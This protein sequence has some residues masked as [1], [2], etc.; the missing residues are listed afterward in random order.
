MGA[1][2]SS[3]AVSMR[4]APTP[5]VLG[6][7]DS[8]QGGEHQGITTALKAK[9]SP[10]IVISRWDPQ[11]LTV[12]TGFNRRF[13]STANW[14]AVCNNA[15]DVKRCVDACGFFGIR[16]TI[17]S[18][19]HCYENF[20]VENS[21]GMIIDCAMMNGVS[22]DASGE[23]V[24][25]EPGIYNWQASLAMFKLFNKTLPSGSCYSVCA[26]GHICGGGY[27]LL[28]RLYGVTSDYLAGVE[29]VT[30]DKDKRAKVVVAMEDS[31]DEDMQNLAWASTGSGGC[32][33]GVITKYYF[34]HSLL[35]AAPE[36]AFLTK[37]SIPFKKLSKDTFKNIYRNY[38]NY[39]N[40]QGKE[41]RTWNMFTLLKGNWAGDDCSKSLHINIQTLDRDTMRD[42]LDHMGIDANWIFVPED[43]SL[44]KANV[45][46]RR[47]PVRAPQSRTLRLTNGLDVPYLEY[48]WLTCTQYLNASGE[49][50][51]FKNTG[52]NHTKPLTEAMLDTCWK[53]QTMTSED[54]P[55]KFKRSDGS[56]QILAPG[57]A[58][59]Q[60]DSYGGRV[61]YNPDGSPVPST[62]TAVSSRTSIMKLQYQAYWYDAEDD[63]INKYFVNNFYKEMYAATDGVPK[64]SHSNGTDGAYINY[65][66]VE[67]GLEQQ[68]YAPLY[69][70]SYDN[71]ARL[72]KTKRR[73]DPNNCFHFPQSIQSQPLLQQS[74]FEVSA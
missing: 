73:W 11:W 22:S 15:E 39:W 68:Q 29:M 52:A 14:Y 19:Y 48:P 67:L 45:E 41:K 23:F 33:F 59:V 55:R 12:K 49:N 65:P 16:P 20:A 46:T 62:K 8:E 4:E 70:P 25:L 47:E 61:N 35:P 63:E 13:N 53:W 74:D 43:A 7:V 9:M 60:M 18:G 66:A 54:L 38:G 72:Q 10:T 3:T 27:G 56:P 26:G 64:P 44:H 31:K 36:S 37:L 17:G 71:Y 30:M 40:E 28:S 1:C 2:V 42:F 57:G 6:N 34:K 51:R 24:V 58:L 21:G 50:R 32:Q 69:W 5:V